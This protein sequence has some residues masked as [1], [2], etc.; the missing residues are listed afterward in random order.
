MEVELMQVIRTNLLKRGKGTDKD[1]VRKITQYWSVD[2]NLL[3]EE[4][5]PWEK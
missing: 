3:A 1:P 2:G 5:D 4:K